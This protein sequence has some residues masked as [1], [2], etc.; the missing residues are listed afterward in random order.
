[1]QRSAFQ[2][3]FYVRRLSEKYG[4]VPI[5]VRYHDQW[6]DVAVWLQTLRSRL[7]LGYQG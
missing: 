7:T 2:V 4:Q 1:M 5:M 6:H 3:F